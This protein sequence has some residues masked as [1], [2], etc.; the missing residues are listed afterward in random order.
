MTFRLANRGMNNSQRNRLLGI[1]TAIGTILWVYIGAAQYVQ[2]TAKF[3]TVTWRS[4][5]AHPR[6][7]WEVHCTVGT[8][9][10][11]MDGLFLKDA[12]S[13][14]WFTGTNIILHHAT[15]SGQRRTWISSSVDGNPG[16]PVRQADS[17]TLYGRVAWLAFCSGPHLRRDGRKLYPSSD[18]WKQVISAPAGFAD[19]TSVFD[20]ALGL[21]KSIRLEAV[22]GFP[23]LQYSVISSTNISGWS[24]PQEFYLTQYRPSDVPDSNAVGPDGWEIDFIIKGSVITIG[25]GTEPEIPIEVI[26]APKN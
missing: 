3:E 1:L 16:K 24:F 22:K 13:T 19:R 6:E 23:A 18:L 9:M 20:D 7:P 12:K 21:P 4:D 17:L 25:P 2:L 5:G 14:A 26:A 15:S 10:W 8:N 11:R